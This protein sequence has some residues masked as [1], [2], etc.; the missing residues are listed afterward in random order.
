MKEAFVDSTGEAANF[1]DATGNYLPLICLSN[2]AN[3]YENTKN[4]YNLTYSE[5]EDII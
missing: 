3:G 5:Y 1:C 4:L 2:L